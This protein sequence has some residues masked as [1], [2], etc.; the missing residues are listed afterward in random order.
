MI[1]EESWGAANSTKSECGLSR[2]SGAFND[3]PTVLQV[4]PPLA[5][6][7]QY[8]FVDRDLILWDEHANLIVDVLPDAV[9]LDLS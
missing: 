8:R 4:F 2:R 1:A 6:E 7:L 9:L 5:E 3:V